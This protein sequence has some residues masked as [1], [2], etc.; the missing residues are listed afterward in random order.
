M[1]STIWNDKRFEG[2]DRTLIKERATYQFMNSMGKTR[3][4]W[5]RA[6]RS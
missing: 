6:G 2:Q 4:I 1:G 3:S 5:N